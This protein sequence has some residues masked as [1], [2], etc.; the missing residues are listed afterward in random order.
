MLK[1]II[2]SFSFAYFS[3]CWIRSLDPRAVPPISAPGAFPEAAPSGGLGGALA[4]AP[5]PGSQTSGGFTALCSWKF[6][7][8]P[9]LDSPPWVPG[10]C[11]PGV[12][13]SSCPLICASTSFI[14]FLRAM[15]GHWGF[16]FASYL[17]LMVVW[18]S[19]LGKSSPWT[20]IFWLPVLL[21][22]WYDAVSA[23]FLWAFLRDCLFSM[24]HKLPN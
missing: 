2:L 6:L 10:P 20:L 17:V 23:P 14:R 13:L 21:E 7:Y 22:V 8:S 4:A 24:L 16:A 11:L 1:W 3:M 12:Y 18:G 5:A 9:R 15:G 19:C